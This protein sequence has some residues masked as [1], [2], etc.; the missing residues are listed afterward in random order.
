MP[1]KIVICKN[2]QTRY[3]GKYCP[4]CGQKAT[5]RR[6]NWR[7]LWDNLACSITNADRGILFTIKELFTRPG[8]M[9]R[10][11]LAGK[12]VNYFRPFS[13][14]FVVAAAYLILSI[15]IFPERESLDP[16]SKVEKT[17]GSTQAKNSSR[18]VAKGG[19]SDI[20]EAIAE[21]IFDLQE[22]L[23]YVMDTPL[24]RYLIAQLIDHPV[25]RS[26]LLLFSIALVMPLIF[27]R[28][29]GRKYNYVEYLFIG[30]YMTC[31]RFLV[32]IV[33]LPYMYWI[34]SAN[35]LLVVSYIGLTAWNHKQL[36][37]MRWPAAIWKTLLLMIV[38]FFV[39]LILGAILLTLFLVGI[40]GVALLLKG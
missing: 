17:T 16:L 2:C 4:N 23:G 35:F 39:V 5:V 11:Y 24:T 25:P 10:N 27:R 7:A 9:M 8:Y 32:D 40:I 13:M 34:G 3:L 19:E 14:L 38:A 18:F 1:M 12:R 28:N 26:I 6:L 37:G 31:Q 30:A 21:F 22:E 36:F 15:Y 29:G 20:G 33:L